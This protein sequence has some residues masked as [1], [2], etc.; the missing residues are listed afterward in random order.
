[1]KGNDKEHDEK[2]DGELIAIVEAVLFS[3]PR[4]ISPGEFEENL[5]RDKDEIMKAL[6]RLEK[7]YDKHERGI[8]LR[9]LRE[10]YLLAARSEF[11][12]AV[13]EVLSSKRQVSLS[14]AALET[15][16]I[17]AYFQPVTRSEIEEVRGVRADATLRTLQKYELIEERG[18]R[19]KPGRP[20]EY[21][22]T[23]NFLKHFGL[24]DLSELPEREKIDVK[25]G[26]SEEEEGV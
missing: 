11:A 17:I 7:H 12:D 25:L 24:S 8:K 1:M 5:D 10:G 18:R 20:I 21:G 26:Q 16:A 6:N 13:E 14:E 22:T 15:L 4:P 3:A 9:R 23:D 19:D 2:I